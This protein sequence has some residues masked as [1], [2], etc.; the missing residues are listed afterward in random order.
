MVEHTE[1]L[2]WTM[3]I[4]QLFSRAI[5]LR[6]G[7]RG[8]KAHSV[9]NVSNLLSMETNHCKFFASSIPLLKEWCYNY[10]GRGLNACLDADLCLWILRSN[11]S[12]S[13]R[14]AKKDCSWEFLE[15]KTSG[16]CRKLQH[17]IA[18]YI[19][20]QWSHFRNVTKNFL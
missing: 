16:N 8:W 17:A 18:S 4:E 10:Q 19:H 13:G 14:E 12:I 1:H 20:K 2:V 15:L 9:Q 11:Q 3:A 5:S 7:F 6:L